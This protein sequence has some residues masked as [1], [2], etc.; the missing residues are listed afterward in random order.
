LRYEE[1]ARL[2]RVFV[3]L[4]VRR[5]RLTGG[6]PLVRPGLASLVE[7]LR[8][9]APALEDLAMTTN[10]Q[11]LAARAADLARAGLDRVNVSLDTLWPDRYRA[12]A[13]GELAPVLAGL[14]AADAVG[15]GPVKLNVVL[16]RGVNDDEIGDFVRLTFDRDVAVRF[17]ELMPLGLD[18]RWSPS[19][20]VTEGEVRARI[21]AEHGPLED[22]DGPRTSRAGGAARVRG[23]RGTLAFISPLTS[24]FCRECNRLRLTADGRLRLCLLSDRAV[25][26]GGPL[27]GGASDETLRARIVAAALEKPRGHA[28]GEEVRCH[29]TTPM[30]AIGG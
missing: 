3:T 10:G 20:V 1:I 22:V 5:V 26:L 30:C 18:P 21:E 4:G 25:D 29:P 6:E 7:L 27:R 24:P 15:L 2:V 16:L 11:R 12:I 14:A 13:G 17:I 28:L 9:E 19:D 8:R 23:A